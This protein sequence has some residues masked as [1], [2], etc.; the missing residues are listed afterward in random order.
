MVRLLAKQTSFCLV[1]NFC[2]VG[3]DPS[4]NDALKLVLG[5]ATKGCGHS[6]ISS[7]TSK[8]LNGAVQRI[9]SLYSSILSPTTWCGF[10]EA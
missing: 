5:A 2:V 1:F 6:P 3:P 10:T 8:T 7:Q 9:K 4:A